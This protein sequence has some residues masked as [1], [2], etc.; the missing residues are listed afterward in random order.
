MSSSQSKHPMPPRS[1]HGSSE[2]DPDKKRRRTSDPSSSS[3]TMSTAASAASSLQLTPASVLASFAPAL[4]PSL[5]LRDLST[6]GRAVFASTALREALLLFRDAPI[7]LLQ[8]QKNRRR[9]LACAFCGR[10]LGSLAMQLRL[11][12]GDDGARQRGKEGA[13]GDDVLPGLEPGDQLLA[14]VVRC[15][16]GCG[17]AYCSERC[18]ATAWYR[19]HEL[20][21]AGDAA[22]ASG[23]CGGDRLS[24]LEKK[25]RKQSRNAQRRAGAYRAADLHPMVAFARH[26][27]RHHQFFL[28][29]AQVVATLVLHGRRGGDVDALL[30]LLSDFAQKPWVDTIDLNEGFDSPSLTSQ[31][32]AES[33]TVHDQPAQPA[34][35]GE[36]GSPFHYSDDGYNPD[37]EDHLHDEI[38]D[39]REQHR[40]DLRAHLVRVVVKSYHLLARALFTVR[41]E[42][43]PDWMNV[44]WYGRLLGLFR[45][46]NVAVE[47]RNPLCEYVERVD[48]LE[49][50]AREEAVRRLSSRV[51]R[52]MEEREREVQWERQ[53]DQEAEDDHADSEDDPSDGKDHPQRAEPDEAKRTEGS[54][55]EE[56]SD[57]EDDE[58]FRKEDDDGYPVRMFAWTPQSPLPSPST[59]AASKSSVGASGVSSPFAAD[60]PSSSRGDPPAAGSSPVPSPAAAE[61]PAP[62]ALTFAST[63]FPSY[64]GSAL[65]PTLACVNHSCAPNA[66][67]VFLDDAR[68]CLMV[69]AGPGAGVVGEGE[70]VTISYI[71]TEELSRESRR[72]G[73]EGYGFECVCRLCV[74]EE[75]AQ[76]ASSMEDSTHAAAVP[77]A[78]EASAS[79]GTS[80]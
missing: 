24:Y 67:V 68:A 33:E 25:A 13:D 52:A 47:L 31:T 57:S 40:Q 77:A 38:D 12:S 72:K 58:S 60:A 70:E 29:A 43:T 41:G 17:E 55:D 22:A 46:N 15:P 5:H 21:C 42:G 63:L 28:M 8:F 65:Y 76:Q 51:A 14:S 19:H 10:F 35:G 34:A 61:S 2:D 32:P 3:P 80:A 71:D 45:L 39:E 4:P 62:G 48:G 11:L 27:H 78:A 18:R 75:R 44:G 79:T 69:K 64:H 59:H 30:S 6:A 16:A 7:A 74:G 50:E 1:P 73:L 23:G 54:D 37:D 20:L 26:A 56:R 36:D 49:G 53:M 66:D 9:V